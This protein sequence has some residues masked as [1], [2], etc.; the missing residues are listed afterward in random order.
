MSFIILLASLRV[1]KSR[2][3]GAF[4]ASIAR[5]L[6]QKHM[7]RSIS[8]NRLFLESMSLCGICDL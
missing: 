5:L 3:W 4:C 6:K 2:S 8:V 7:S 1:G